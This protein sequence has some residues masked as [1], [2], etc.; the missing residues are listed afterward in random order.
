MTNKFTYPTETS[1]TSTEGFLIQHNIYPVANVVGAWV[2]NPQFRITLTHKPNWFHRVMV[3]LLLGWK[4]EP[5][6]RTD[7]YGN[8]IPTDKRLL[9][10]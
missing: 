8:P 1:S 9:H 7:M 3:R 10:G 2:V 4:Y 6:M 5:V